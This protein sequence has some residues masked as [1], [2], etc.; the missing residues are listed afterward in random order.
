MLF[1]AGTATGLTDGQLLERFATRGG[2]PAETAFTALVERHG[3]MVWRVCRAI[4]GDDHEAEDAF[5][6]TFLVLVR[7][8]R[9]LWVRDSLGPWL[10]RVARRAA[11]R[12]RV[13]AGRRR[14]AERGAMAMR[15]SQRDEPVGDELV[16]L[17]H[18]EIDRLPDRFRMPVVL[19][20][21]EGR[22]Y[23]EA[24]RH[25]HCPVGT[26]KSRLARG[27]E[28]LRGR[29]GR[30]G[31]AVTTGLSVPVVDPRTI[32][33]PPSPLVR[34]TVRAALT[35]A[36]GDAGKSGVISTS[37]ASLAKEISMSMSLQTMYRFIGRDS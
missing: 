25:L 29:L 31:L 28:R 36:A 32:Q 34:T 22:S 37:A 17:I 35:L 1:E 16:A 7:K 21:V 26:V 18:A 9:S 10:H 23:V 12:A 19:C 13:T 30:H 15:D 4:L 33:A 5:Q 14:L 20:D 6:A 2:D 8:S 3:P 27:R 11:V 24:A